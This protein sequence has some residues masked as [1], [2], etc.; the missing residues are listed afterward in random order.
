[1][2]PRVFLLFWFAST[3]LIMNDIIV[4]ITH[5][6]IL[7]LPFYGYHFTVTILLLPFYGYHFTVTITHI[8]IL[9]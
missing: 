4:S 8:T 7:Q 1:M 9:H 5:F 3:M 2:F 6:A